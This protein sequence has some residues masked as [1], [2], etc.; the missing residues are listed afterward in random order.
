MFVSITNTVSFYVFRVCITGRSPVATARV[1]LSLKRGVPGK[2]WD[3]FFAAPYR[4]VSRQNLK[5]GRIYTSLAL[6]HAGKPKSEVVA[7]TGST[8]AAVEALVKARASIAPRPEPS[9]YFGKALGQAELCVAL[10]SCHQ[11]FEVWLTEQ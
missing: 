7:A 2:H 9:V 6:L 8:A 5:N 4:Y 3:T 1:G 11:R 10:L